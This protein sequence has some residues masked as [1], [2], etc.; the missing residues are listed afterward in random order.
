M[1]QLSIAILFFLLLMGLSPYVPALSGIGFDPSIVDAAYANTWYVSTSGD[2]VTGD[3]SI[4]NPW[5]TVAYAANTATANSITYIRAGTYTETAQIVVANSGT[6]GNPI[7]FANYPGESITVSGTAIG[8]G[9]GLIYV[10]GKDY[11]TFS[12][13]SLYGAYY[14][15]YHIQD[16][17]NIIVQDATIT[18]CASSGIYAY[19]S[20]GPATCTNLTFTRNTI[21]NCN[22]S[23]TV[24]EAL[25]LRYTTDVTITYNTVYNDQ[26][27]PVYQTNVKEGIDTLGSISVE[28]AYNEIWGVPLGIYVDGWASTASDQ[29]IH[30]NYIHDGIL[31]NGIQINAEQGGTVSDISIYNNIVEGYPYYG[32]YMMYEGTSYSN[33]YVY[34]NTF[35]NNGYDARFREPGGNVTN[36]VVFN[37]IWD[38]TTGGILFDSGYNTSNHHFG[39]N[40][41]SLVAQSPKP[42]EGNYYGTSYVTGDPDLDANTYVL[43]PTSICVDSGTNSYYSVSAPSDDYY[44]NTRPNNDVCDI[45]A[46]EYTASVAGQAEAL[47]DTSDLTYVIHPGGATLIHTGKY[48]ID[49]ASMGAGNVGTVTMYTRASVGSPTGTAYLTASVFLNGNSITGTK[50]TLTG[51]VTGYS[52]VL[53]RPGGGT[54][55][56]SDLGNAEWWLTVEHN[57]PSWTYGGIVHQ[58]YVGAAFISSSGSTHTVSQAITTGTENA[59][60]CTYDGATQVVHTD[61]GTTSQAIVTTIFTNT[62]P[63]YVAEFDGRVDD[64]MI[65][66]AGTTVLSLDFEPEDIGEST[67]QDKTTNDNDATFVLAENLSCQSVEIGKS[68]ST[69]EIIPLVT[70]L[71]KQEYLDNTWHDDKLTNEEIDNL[72]QNNPFFPIVEMI[73]QFSGIPYWMSWMSMYLL[74]LLISLAW[75]LRHTN[76]HIAIA[77]ATGLLVTCIFYAWGGLIPWGLVA[78]W[79]LAAILSVILERRQTI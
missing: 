50:R 41:Y 47:A 21:H 60:S 4:G 52:D 10:N 73:Y 61:S 12:G 16:A 68:K 54:W 26:A 69:S 51:T 49:T 75:V 18:E 56:V 57:I 45:G 48:K 2:D 28:V 44:G 78:M 79:V 42:P 39:Y 34:N 66:S 27:T 20:G 6:V 38:S 32:F 3:G 23:L 9:E 40:Q 17:D 30:H 72:G 77:A 74:V 1:K 53:T 7:V 11:V 8:S 24:H 36:L 43:T 22:A 19:G 67:I 5:R 70:E 25:S 63:V 31:T 65:T 55:S 33:I 29:Q 35:T 76:S 13:I 64:V 71:E 62:S 14:H 37:N 58:M 15:G 59:V 46:Y